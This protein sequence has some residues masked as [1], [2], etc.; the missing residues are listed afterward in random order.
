MNFVTVGFYR[1]CNSQYE[2]S[3]HLSIRWP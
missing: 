3:D 2:P 1:F